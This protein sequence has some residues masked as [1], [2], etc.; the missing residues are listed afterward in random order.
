MKTI[1]AAEAQERNDHFIPQVYLRSFANNQQAQQDKKEVW[2]YEKPILKDGS[3]STINCKSERIKDVCHKKGWDYFDNPQKKTAFTQY[4]K[5]I[6]KVYNKALQD[7]REGQYSHKAKQYIACNIA[8]MGLWTP[9]RVEL[10]SSVLRLQKDLKKDFEKED[11]IFA[12]ELLSP[13]ILED[14]YLYF[15]MPWTVLLNQ[16]ESLFVTSDNPVCA[17]GTQLKSVDVYI[18]LTPKIGVI[19]HHASTS[20]DLSVQ[21]DRITDTERVKQLNMA[22]IASSDQYVISS[23]QEDQIKIM[24]SSD[25]LKTLFYRGYSLAKILALVQK[26]SATV[27]ATIWQIATTFS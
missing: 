13:K 7:F 8:R 23:T 24:L 2:L 18:P 20:K 22:I 21:M 16:T 3:L 27:D 1:L 5:R 10:F 6:E 19:M 25:C 14:G 15:Q 12:K 11:L 26:T 4:L 9:K 17:L